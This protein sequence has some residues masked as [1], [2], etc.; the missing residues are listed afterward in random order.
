MWHVHVASDL[1]LVHPYRAVEVWGSQVV[2]KIPDKMATNRCPPAGGYSFITS[3][4]LSRFTRPGPGF[5]LSERLTF[6]A[7]MS[8]SLKSFSF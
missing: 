8:E 3:L 2:D 5:C 4:K 6:L 1:P 7:N